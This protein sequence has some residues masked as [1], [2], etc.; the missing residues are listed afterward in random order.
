[1]RSGNRGISAFRDCVFGAL[2]LAAAGA[3]IGAWAAETTV[4]VATNFAEAAAS[5]K[6]DFERQTGHTVALTVGSTGK[7][8]AQVTNGAPFDVFLSA[9]QS[10]AELLEKE[11]H[12]VSGTR[13]TYA[14]G[15]LALWSADATLLADGSPAA[16]RGPKVRHLAI[17]NPDLAPY[18]AAAKQVLERLGL[19]QE[20]VPRI[21]MGQDVGSTFAMVATGN[22]EAGFVALSSLMS[23]VEQPRGSRW[24]VPLELYDPIRQD[25]VQLKRSVENPAAWAFLEF[26][27]SASARATMAHF[28]YAAD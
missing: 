15:R 24:D 26:L 20:L 27:R 18:G 23:A 2:A 25:A 13:F 9:D 22:A 3:A 17:A 1:M 12:A 10:R 21:V 16:L 11:G 5:L 19:W 8:Y 7:L 14:T 28:G 6:P 4:A